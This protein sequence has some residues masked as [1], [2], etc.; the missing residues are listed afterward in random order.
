MA[1]MAAMGTIAADRLWP[2]QD[3]EVVVHSHPR[4]APDDPHLTATPAD[5]RGRHAHPFVI[6]RLHPVWSEGI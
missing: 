3:P 1:L 4:L 5:A 2:A 6:D